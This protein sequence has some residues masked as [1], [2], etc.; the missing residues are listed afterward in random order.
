MAT[1][2]KIELQHLSRSERSS[3]NPLEVTATNRDL[4]IKVFMG[5]LVLAAPISL[6]LSP[7]PTLAPPWNRVTAPQQAGG[8]PLATLYTAV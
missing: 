5:M 8:A 6:H 1:Y 2:V 3:Q 7:F 4:G